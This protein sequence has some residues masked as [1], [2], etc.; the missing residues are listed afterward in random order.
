[1]SINKI[2]AIKSLQIPSKKHYYYYYYYY[3][4]PNK[5]KIDPSKTYK[6]NSGVTQGTRQAFLSHL[7]IITPQLL[8]STKL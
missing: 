6:L 7:H 8:S 2:M 5:N 4:Y 1:M 3:Y